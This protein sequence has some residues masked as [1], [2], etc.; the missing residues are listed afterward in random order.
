MGNRANRKQHASSVHEEDLP[1]GNSLMPPNG[2]KARSRAGSLIK[3]GD[4]ADEKLL[5]NSRNNANIS[6][7]NSLVENGPLSTYAEFK[8]VFNAKNIGGKSNRRQA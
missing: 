3:N 6:S 2:A 4:K 8:N 7:H 5:K 1:E